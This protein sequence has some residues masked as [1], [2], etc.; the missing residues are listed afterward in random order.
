MMKK[1]I[2]SILFLGAVFNSNAQWTNTGNNTTTGKVVAKEFSFSRID[3]D[4]SMKPRTQISPMSIKLFDDYVTTRPGGSSPD[5]NSYGTLLSINGR[6]NHW[7]NNLYFGA[8]TNKMYFR[9]SKYAQHVAENGVKGDF[10]DW[11]TLL[12][13]RSDVKTSGLLKVEGD[14]NHYISKG[15]LGIGTI[16]TPT[17]TLTVEGRSN[18]RLADF[19]IVNESTAWKDQIRIKGDLNTPYGIAFVGKGHHRGGLYAENL[20]T[21]G[22]GNVTLWARNNGR[23]ILD[24]KRTDLKGN[25]KL[26]YAASEHT[27]IQ[28]GHDI[29]D[30]IFADNSTAKSYGGGMFFRVTPAPSLN[31]AHNYLD[32]MMLTDKGNVGIGT[33]KAKA[34]LHVEGVGYIAT[35]V[36]GSTAADL[37]LG[38]KGKDQLILRRDN[39]D[40][41][42]FFTNNT[43]GVKQGNVLVLGSN[44][45]IG[46]G[47]RETKGFKLGVNGKIA[48]TEV[49]V[50]TYS[51]WADF[52]FKK[53]YNLPTLKEV[54]NH[55]KENGHLANIPSAAKVKKDGFFLGEMDAKLLQKIEELTLYTIQQEKDLKNQEVRAKKQST[56]IEKL[57]IENELLKNRLDKIEELLKKLK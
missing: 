12:D 43:G 40:A 15:R 52:V 17:S 47:T 8:Q 25:L 20:A 28:L 11:R 55:I 42:F 6:S 57:K 46:I 38:V 31:I 41:H 3:Y 49:K 19:N 13:S 4:F 16:A 45:N 18:I 21:G 54:E 37:H 23:I 53:D 2:I 27:N 30:R 34:K 32:V 35:K 36:I 56:K 39:N 22:D 29:N 44:G 9:I 5:N 51:N 50:A 26:D 14:G 48:A 24:G 10:N 1:I 7:E 33:G